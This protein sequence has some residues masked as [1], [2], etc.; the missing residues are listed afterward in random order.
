MHLSVLYE[1]RKGRREPVLALLHTPT[2]HPLTR[3]RR[4]HPT[5]FPLLLTPPLKVSSQIWRVVHVFLRE[6]LLYTINII[7]DDLDVGRT[8]LA[9]APVLVV[10][11]EVGGHIVS[12]VLLDVVGEVFRCHDA[13]VFDWRLVALSWRWGRSVDDPGGSSCDRTLVRWVS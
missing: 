7:V 2:N 9:G 3:R 10:G 13:V 5:R 6:R 1:H 4:I 8:V 11:G 12:P